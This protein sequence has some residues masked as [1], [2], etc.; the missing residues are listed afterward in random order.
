MQAGRPW[1]GPSALRAPPPSALLTYLLRPYPV[2]PSRRPG[3]PL[4]LDAGGAGALGWAHGS[5]PL[6][7]LLPGALCGS[8]NIHRNPLQGGCSPWAAD[9]GHASI[10]SFTCPFPFHFVGRPLPGQRWLR[11]RC[12]GTCPDPTWTPRLT[13]DRPA[14]R[15][16][17]RP[18]CRALSSWPRLCENRPRFPSVRTVPR[19]RSDGRP[20]RR[21]VSKAEPGRWRPS[22]ERFIAAGARGPHSLPRVGAHL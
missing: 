12:L 9:V 21:P 6:E 5:Q 11:G 15:T 1:E 16:R 18:Q 7:V 14:T 22:R 19:E 3:S 10:F 2:R 20:A 13:A 8:G 17:G 4:D